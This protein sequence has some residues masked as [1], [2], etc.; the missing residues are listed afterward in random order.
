M[1]NYTCLKKKLEK[2]TVFYELLTSLLYIHAMSV[3]LKGF[4]L[5]H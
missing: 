2:F 1:T 3:Q 4:T 5:I